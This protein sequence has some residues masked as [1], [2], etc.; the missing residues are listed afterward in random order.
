MA[1]T[2]LVFYDGVLSVLELSYAVEKNSP[3]PFLSVFWL[4]E[5]NKNNTIFFHFLLLIMEY[6]MLIL[7]VEWNDKSW[8]AFIVL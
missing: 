8:L 6:I 2:F 1:K 3:L 4:Y 7:R 5:N